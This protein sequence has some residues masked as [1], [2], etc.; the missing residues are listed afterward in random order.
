MRKNVHRLK[1]TL[2]GG[3]VALTLVLFLWPTDND[4]M[5]E[6]SAT[7]D[8]ASKGK[9]LIDQKKPSLKSAQGT[10]TE[11]AMQGPRF[12][13]ETKSGDQWLVSADKAVARADGTLMLDVV[14]AEVMVGQPSAVEIVSDKGIFKRLENSVIL[15]NGIVAKGRGYTFESSHLAASLKDGNVYSNKPVKVYN[16]KNYIYAGHF[17]MRDNGDMITFKK[18][19]TAHFVIGK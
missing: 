11:T 13:G 12:S 5:V 1:F 19:V 15:N 10:V 9:E 2:V 6:F 18:G 4:N 8:L 3:A 16:G 17:D 14:Y 7:R